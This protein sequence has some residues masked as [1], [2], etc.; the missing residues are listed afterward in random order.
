MDL[1]ISSDNPNMNFTPEQ[2]NQ[3]ITM[4]TER[5]GKSLY[6]EDITGGNTTDG[7]KSRFVY[8]S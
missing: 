7:F 3:L 1:N 4:I 5:I 2:K 8:N 6:N